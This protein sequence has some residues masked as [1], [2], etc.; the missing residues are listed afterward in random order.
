[1]WA[2]EEPGKRGKDVEA[3]M[4]VFARGFVPASG[5]VVVPRRSGLRALPR[6]VQLA[7]AIPC[8]WLVGM[9]IVL[10]FVRSHTLHNLIVYVGVALFTVGGVCVYAGMMAY[11][12]RVQRGQA[13]AARERRHPG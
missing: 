5:G 3:G 11:L 2:N 13:N 6:S 8:A 10:P 4:R 1:M 7:L 12:R 9:A